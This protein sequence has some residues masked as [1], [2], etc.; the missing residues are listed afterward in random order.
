MAALNRIRLHI[1]GGDYTLT[2]D[3]PEEYVRELA[4]TVDERISSVLKADNRIST[5]MAAILTCLDLADE[6][7]KSADSADNLRGQIQ[8]YL[9]D[10]GSVRMELDAARR[11]LDRLRRENDFLRAKCGMS[12]G[13]ND[14]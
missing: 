7:R 13:S 9:E 5:M 11:E 8:G 12:N 3:E 10:N 14:R 6:S 2:T 4:R 1:A